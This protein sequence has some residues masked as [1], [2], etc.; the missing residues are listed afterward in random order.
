MQDIEQG[1]HLRCHYSGFDVMNLLMKQC[2]A[3]VL[4]K[5]TPM[6]QLNKD[7]KMKLL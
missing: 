7:N 4:L 5:H 6:F 2:S 1:P 3:A